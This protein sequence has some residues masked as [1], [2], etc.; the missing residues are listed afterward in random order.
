[1]FTFNQ[2]LVPTTGFNDLPSQQIKQGVLEAR[3]ANKKV[4][5]VSQQWFNQVEPTLKSLAHPVIIGETQA[6][7][8]ALNVTF[9]VDP[10]L[11]DYQFEVK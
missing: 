4:I 6:D 7:L 10:T 2:T 5:G 8:V 3:A 1:M 9:Y 11:T